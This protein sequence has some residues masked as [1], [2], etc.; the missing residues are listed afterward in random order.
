MVIRASPAL[1]AE[2]QQLLNALLLVSSSSPFGV[3]KKKPR[4]DAG[5]LFRQADLFYGVKSSADHT[6]RAGGTDTWGSYN[7]TIWNTPAA[8][9]P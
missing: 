4:R 6:L 7:E 1:L 3:R 2:L 9:P 5:A 8:P